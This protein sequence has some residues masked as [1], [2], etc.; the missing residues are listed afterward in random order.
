MISTASSMKSVIEA[1]E[2]GANGYVRKPFDIDELRLVVSRSIQAADASERLALLED[3]AGK[4]LKEAVEAY[5]R[6]LIEQALHRT[7]G[8]QTHAA[9]ELGTTR[10][11]L[12]YRIE[13]LGIEIP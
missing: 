2:L 10:R 4:S 11:I 8:V 7:G 6:I 13:K 3:T 12:R 9:E 1:M 5:E